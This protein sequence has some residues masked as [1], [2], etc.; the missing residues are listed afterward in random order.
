MDIKKL[1]KLISC[2]RGEIPSDILL[3]NGT[4]INTLT[5]EAYKADIAIVEDRI[6]NVA[7]P[8]LIDPTNTNNLLDMRGKF[9]A[10]GFI[11]SHLH[12]ESTMLNPTE[13]AKLACMNGTTTVLLDPHEIGNALGIHGLELLYNETKNLPVRFLIEI[14]SCV[15]A[16]PGLETSGHEI[17]SEAIKKLLNTESHY[18]G[19]GE[20]MNFPGVLFKDD[21]VLKK[22]ILGRKMNII[23]GHSPGLSGKD[24]DAYIST[25]I[26]SDHES[27][28][29][30]ELLEKLRK[31]MR[32][33]IREG[34]LAKDLKNV[35]QAVKGKD[36]DLRNCLLCSDDRNILDLYANGHMNAH[37]RLSVEEGISPL[38]ALQMVT[39]NPATYLGLSNDLGSISPGKIADL[40]ILNDLKDFK[41]NTVIYGGKLVYNEKRLYWNFPQM[42]YPSW[43]TNS[44][45]LPP[46][47]KPDDFRVKSALDNGFY[48]VRVIGVKPHSLITDSLEEH[49]ELKNGWFLPQ[50]EHDILFLSVIERYGKNGNVAT[51]FIKGFGIN[52]KPFAMAT[53]VAHDTHN[54]IVTG[55]D[56]LSMIKAVNMLHQIG[57]GY[58]IITKNHI[59]KVPL[60][61][62]GIMSLEVSEVLH[63][64]LIELNKCFI[65]ITDFEEPLMALSF[66]ALP[67]IP[68]LKLT[69]KGLV[70][71][72]EFA[73]ADLV[74]T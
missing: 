30:N 51:A 52:T 56:Q 10:P 33:M 19:L 24:L 55:T 45:Q 7:E 46:L 12:L 72:D 29:A 66:M 73:F 27:T 6:S 18:F 3:Q 74:I 59:Q 39:I 21:E 17:N 28:T 54:I 32:V 61:Y 2:A 47:L 37:L 57:G 36:L 60:Q 50:F 48:T 16:A 44:V 1:K 69:D 42:K 53:S 11:E 26:G 5:R 49:L 58:V 31:G 4:L 70:N 64:Q 25:G 13:F 41:I 14:P 68:H 43:A 20:V 38:I 65:G 40:V 23:D 71:V 15:P 22:I 34:S 8:G 63:K 67:V 62:G 9:I 35:I